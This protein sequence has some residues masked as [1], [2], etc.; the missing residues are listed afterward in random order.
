LLFYTQGMATYPARD[1]SYWMET[2]EKTAYEPLTAHLETDVA[3]VGG[4]IAGLTTAYLLKRQGKKVAVIEKGIIGDCI[5]GY[6]T[7]KITSQHSTTYTDLIKNFG[8]E[9][10]R[11]YGEA[12]QA[13][14]AQMERIIT[15]E[16]IE[17]DWRREDNYVFTEKPAEV[18]KLRQEA[19]DA[20]RL[21]MPASFELTSPLPFQI[22][23]AVKFAD[24][25]TFHIGKYL[26]G[27]AA[28]IHGGGSYVFENTKASFFSGGAHPSFIT[29][30]GKVT[31]RDVV[32]ATNVPTPIVMHTYY[33]FL[34]YPS[35]SYIVA[36]KA[37]TQLPGMYINTGGPGRSILPVNVAGQNYLLIGGEGHIVGLSGPRSGRYDALSDYAAEHFDL[38]TD[39]RWTA[40]DYIAY[41]SVPLIGKAYP[42]SKH[43]YVATGFRKWGLSTATVAAIILR[44]EIMGV[45]NPWAHTFRSNRLS[46]VTSLPK[47]IAQGIRSSFF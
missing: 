20:A 31:A 43:M 21:G 6:T 4:G 10:A 36:G 2:T 42:R 11:L 5:S 37:N 32:I 27:L 41:D 44:D 40:W 17:C 35:R 12:N 14:I 9:N 22:Q 1:T 18:T 24:Q 33:G 3:I 26:Q 7:G 13:A 23:A 29:P 19:D 39:Y 47:G 46:A 45:E 28:A 25:A 16:G 30:G 15:E 38:E 34:E 8:D